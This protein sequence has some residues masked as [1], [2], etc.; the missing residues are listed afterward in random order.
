MRALGSPKMPWTVTRGRKPGKQYV[1]ANRRGGCIE[2]SCHVFSQRKTQQTL[3]QRHVLALRQDFLPTR[4]AED[5]I[6]WGDR[7]PFPIV[8]TP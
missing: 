2:K 7:G 5:P 3:A 8:D 1:S 6:F 4:N